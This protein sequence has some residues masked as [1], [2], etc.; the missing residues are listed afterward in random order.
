MDEKYKNL[1]IEERVDILKRDL[2]Q[3]IVNDLFGKFS[4]LGKG[5][6]ILIYKDGLT[7]NKSSGIFRVG[8]NLPNLVENQS[9]TSS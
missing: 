9:I 1:T 7:F 3:E 5:S 6:E 4:K 8:K 2:P